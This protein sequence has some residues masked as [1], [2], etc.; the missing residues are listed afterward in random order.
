MAA[1]GLWPAGRSFAQLGPDERTILLHGYWR[2]PGPG[3]FLKSPKADP[4]EVGSWLRWDGLFRAALGEADRS[5][6]RA[7]VDEIRAT[8]RRV[9]CPVCDG[10]GLQ[11]QSRAVILGS[12]SFFDWVREGTVGELVKALAKLDPASKRS[13][14]MRARVIHCL[15]PVSNAAPKSLLRNPVGDV[16]L[17]RAVFQRVVRSQTRLEVLG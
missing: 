1:E 7:W 2:R 5:K 3:S 14:M 9:K 13:K 17:I 6:A 11:P 16:E 12:R 10:T 4:A 8:T 15:E